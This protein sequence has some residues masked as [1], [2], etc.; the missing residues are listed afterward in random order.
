MNKLILVISLTLSFAWIS[1][2]RTNSTLIEDDSLP[3]TI[4]CKSY[5]HTLGDGIDSQIGTLICDDMIFNY[6]Y[7]RYSS[8][9]PITLY[10]SFRKSF[11]AYHYS[12][13]FDA[14]F[15]D[16]QVRDVLLDSVTI[17]K[18]TTEKQSGKYIVDCPDC[19]ATAILTFNNREFLYGFSQSPKLIES[20]S[21]YDTKVEA[22]DQQYYKKTYSKLNSDK[23][24][25]YLAPTGNPRKN[26]RKNKLNITTHAKSNQN[27]IQ[28][29]KS[30]RL[31]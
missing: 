28:I 18:V 16:E 2:N 22:T 14:I 7:G 20:Q 1:C 31:K 9:K 24:G 19:N 30:I 17:R 8:D 11:Y 5:L 27:L 10:E 15:I 13:F 29:L 21:N 26:R 4:E 23:H 6:E 12:K 25:V 3:F